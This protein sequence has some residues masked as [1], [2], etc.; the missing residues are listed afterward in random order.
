MLTLLFNQGA[1][2]VD[3]TAAGVAAN[4]AIGSGTIDITF[5]LSGAAAS[6]AIGASRIDVTF[7]FSGV[8]ASPAIG[9]T[10]IDVNFA[11]TG[12][13]ASPAIG[14]GSVVVDVVV[15]LTGAD[16]AP[17]IGIG[18]IAADFTLTGTAA[19]PATGSFVEI[20]L[21]FSITGAA[22]AP[23]I[24]NGTIDG[25]TTTQ[26]DQSSGGVWLDLHSQSIPI[27]TTRAFGAGVAARP[28]I[29]EGT[30]EI[31]VASERPAPDTRA[32]IGGGAIDVDLNIAYGVIA[33]AQVNSGRFITMRRRGSSTV[34]EAA[35]VSAAPQI[36][37]GG[38]LVNVVDLYDEE[39]IALLLAA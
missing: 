20:D 5:A 36:G 27:G 35:G 21:D 31:T 8:A 6:P 25:A 38:R 1:A 9:A 3:V 13:A 11:V 12:V 29:G 10:R 4:A 33:N 26:S 17:G 14:T 30:I 23:A 28:A 32:A 7:P 15:Q 39:I 24:G 16:A 19:A 37:R 34:V 2:E 18:A 22:A